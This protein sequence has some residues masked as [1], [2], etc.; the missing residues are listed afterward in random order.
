VLQGVGSDSDAFRVGADGLQH[1]RRSES[2]LRLLKNDGGVT[3]LPR[4]MVLQCRPGRVG[5]LTVIVD[6]VV[7]G[8]PR[9]GQQLPELNSTATVLM[10]TWP[11]KGTGQT[12]THKRK[13]WRP[14][15]R[16]GARSEATASTPTPID[17]QSDGRGV[18]LIRASEVGGRGASE[19]V[20]ESNEGMRGGCGEGWRLLTRTRSCSASTWHP[21]VGDQGRRARPGGRDKEGNRGGAAVS[22]DR[23][24]GFWNEVDVG[25]ARESKV[26][27]GSCPPSN[28]STQELRSKEAACVQ[29]RARPGFS[30]R[31]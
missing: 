4:A 27:E 10:D 6:E 15:E 11:G 21:W 16:E 12:R 29:V 3:E 9:P 13:A 18:P 14:R 22:P 19:G 31:V 5:V 8:A 24:E 26:K 23:A 20:L 2:S 30:E 7:L 25:V 28:C 1:R 17:M